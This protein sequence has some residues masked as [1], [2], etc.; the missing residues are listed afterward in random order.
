MSQ[1]ANPSNPA[2]QG[3]RGQDDQRKSGPSRLDGFEG[4]NYEQNRGP[5][6]PRM[7]DN[8]ESGKQTLPG[9]HSHQP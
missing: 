2:Q 1:Q 6:Q 5:Y 4:M 9:Q 8:R 3:G 7:D